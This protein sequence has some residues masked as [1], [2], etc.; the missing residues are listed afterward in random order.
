[1]SVLV[2]GL[3]TSLVSCAPLLKRLGLH[4]FLKEEDPSAVD[5]ADV[6]PP[7][8]EDASG[9]RSWSASFKEPADGY[10]PLAALG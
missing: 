5:A 3:N 9:W 10:N 6:V 4:D 7:K 2:E 8:M 1:M